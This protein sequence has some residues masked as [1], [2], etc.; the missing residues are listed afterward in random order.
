MNLAALVAHCAASGIRVTFD[1]NDN[2]RVSPARLVTRPVAE[3]FREHKVGLLALRRVRICGKDYPIVSDAAGA[4]FVLSPPTLRESVEYEGRGRGHPAAGPVEAGEA[5]WR[6]FAATGD[7]PQL[8]L[9]LDALP[10][11]G[12]V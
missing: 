9:L 1:D 4:A 12:G 5:T 7:D 10:A 2:L 6:R 8:L 3:A 11:G